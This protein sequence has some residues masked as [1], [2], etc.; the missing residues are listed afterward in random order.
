[1]Q[2]DPTWHDLFL[3][4]EGRETKFIGELGPTYE[5]R[6]R[7][8]DR[9]GNVETWSATTVHT[10]FYTWGITG[11]QMD[12]AGAP[13]TA[14]SVTIDPIAFDV[15][16]D[17][18]GTYAAYLADPTYK[19]PKLIWQKQEYGTL[20]GTGFS[21]ALDVQRNIVLLPVNNLLTNSHFERA[22]L[23]GWQS[24]GDL[25]PVLNQNYHHTG[26]ASVM[27]GCSTLAPAVKGSTLA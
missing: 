2:P 5:F 15:Q 24:K 13:V 21:Q 25:P 22:R 23:D 12:N 16:V 19:D 3:E 11:N 4:Y 8:R 14:A 20:P 27:F 18:P 7:T 17:H 10:T 1:M 6:L 9:A 26:Q